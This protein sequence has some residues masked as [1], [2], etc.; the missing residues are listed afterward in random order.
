SKIL[1]VGAIA[2]V[3]GITSCKKG[4]TGPAGAQGAQGNAGPVLTGNLKG[5]INHFDLSGAKIST[6]LAGDSVF[7]DNTTQTA[8]TDASGMFSFSGLS[9]GVYNLTVKRAGYGWTKIQSVQF[10]GG[11]D[12]YRNGNISNI[13]T[14]NANT[15]MAYD[16]TISG[17]NYVRVR[18]TIPATTYIQ[19]LAV[20]VG[21]PGNSTVNSSS[22]N[23]TS[24]YMIN[25]AVNA[26]TYSKNI[27]TA[28]LYDLGYASGNTVYMAAYTIGGNANASSYVDETNDKTV[29]TAIGTT[30]LYANAAVQ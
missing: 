3:L 12:L 20:F 15:F 4:D 30:P 6:G 24:V 8:V 16:T 28:E 21:N 10:T 5:Y 11:G 25:I 19:T 26:T 22:T 23:Q 1:L 17:V 27:P 13:P 29:Y 9:T 7:I 14:T 2:F 18:G